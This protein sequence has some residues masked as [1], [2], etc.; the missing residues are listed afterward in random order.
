MKIRHI[1]N[2]YIFVIIPAILLAANALFLKFLARVNSNYMT[3]SDKTARIIM[4][5]LATAPL[6]S[7][8]LECIGLARAVRRFRPTDDE[9]YI[10]KRNKIRY[11]SLFVG[12]ILLTVL[13]LGSMLY[14]TYQAMK[15]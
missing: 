12:A 8:I 2:K 5:S 13:W 6:V 9:P 15:S 4:M 14:I 3:L 10:V 11:I 7:L 1:I